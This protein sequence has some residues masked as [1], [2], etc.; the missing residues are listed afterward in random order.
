[1]KF[2]HIA[3]CHLGAWKNNTHKEN[4]LQAFKTAITTSIKEKVN[5]IIIAGD[6]FHSAVPDFEIADQTFKILKKCRTHHIPIYMVYGSHDRGI[7]KATIDLLDTS[8]IITHIPQPKNYLPKFITD[9]Q[10][11][12]KI[13]GIDGRSIGIETDTYAHYNKRYLEKED[14]FKVF[15]FHTTIKD[16]MEWT[17]YV[18][19]GIYRHNLPEG[20]EYYAGG[21]IH[22]PSQCK[23]ETH[24]NIIIPGCLYGSN[25]KDLENTS[26]GM[27]RGFYIIHFTDKVERVEFK[28]IKIGDLF[29]FN[30]D[31][32]DK[33]PDEINETI[34]GFGEVLKELGSVKGKTALIK[35][36]GTL[37]G[38]ES[39]QIKIGT[40][41]DKLKEL[42][43]L[44]VN[45]NTFGIKTMEEYS[46]VEVFENETVEDIERRIFGQ[47]LAKFEK[48]HPGVMDRLMEGV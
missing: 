5:F 1:M 35:F 45:I 42:G 28:P 29:Y 20:F 21:H 31:V 46:A 36:K 22:E 34:N 37:K 3:D 14:G 39:N 12:V 44:D 6:L 16:C 47:E 33:H 25:Y 38:G 24:P 7:N 11:G 41:R 18:I 40:F 9:P 27:E 8:E 10:T 32:T 48:K 4:N 30:F 2:A 43:A 23:D 19:P 13:T 15:V 17:G 26:K